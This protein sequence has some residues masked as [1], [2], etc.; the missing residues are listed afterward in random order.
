L[1]A[2]S[3]GIFAAACFSK[4]AVAA[5]DNLFDF[6]RYHFL[7]FWGVLLI[8]VISGGVT[9]CDMHVISQLLI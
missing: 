8:H 1:L 4:F 7:P 3:T 2:G 9:L 6:I 5:F